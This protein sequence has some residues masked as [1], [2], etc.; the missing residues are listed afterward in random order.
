MRNHFDLA[1]IGGGPGGYP[2]AIRAARLGMRVALIEKQQLGGTCLN[3]GCI[4]TKALL[5]AAEL[6]QTIKTSSRFGVFCSDVGF[7]YEKIT[8]YK[9]NTVSQLVRGVEQL[10]EANDVTVFHGR[11]TL[12]SQSD[13]QVISGGKVCLL[14]ANH[15]ILATGSRPEILPL[16]GAKLPNVLDSDSLLE[17]RSIPESLI[18][19]GGG[20]IGVEF[21]ETLSSLGCRVT[22]LESQEEI[23]SAMGH[24]ISQNLRLILKKRGLDI[25]TGVSVKEIRQEE[26]GLITVFQEKGEEQIAFSQYILC[27]VGRIPN[28]EGLFESDIKPEMRQGYVLVDKDQQT[29]IKGVY[30]IGDLVKGVHLAHAASAQ[31]ITTAER[32]AGKKPSID[33]TTV[34]CCVYTN[35]EIAAVGMTEDEAKAKNIDVHVGSFRMGAN[36]KIVITGADRSFINIVASAKTGEILGAQMMC[37]RASDMIGEFVTAIA[38]HLTVTQLLY[39]MRA[40]PTYNEGVGEALQRLEGWG[41]HSL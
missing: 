25:R 37:P 40:H 17:L 2:A 31:G 34:P 27:A 30:A 1:V 11:G 6:Y 10:L 13:V 8:E 22:I 23:L 36:G 9:D 18:I 12:Q 32:L 14:N 39:G 38:N 21:A 29:S 28:S 19:V 35:P 33:I 16:P 7:D 4:P 15:I 26:S 41:I 3:R 5:H 24:Q 20:V